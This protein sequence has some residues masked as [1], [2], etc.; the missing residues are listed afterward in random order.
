MNLELQRERRLK[1]RTFGGISMEMAIRAEIT[2]E[3]WRRVQGP[4]WMRC[5][6]KIKSVE[7]G[8]QLTKD[9][10]KEQLMQKEEIQE[11]SVTWKPKEESV[12]RR[13]EG[14]LAWLWLRC[15]K[16]SVSGFGHR[17]FTEDL[18]GIICRWLELVKEGTGGR[19]CLANWLDSTSFIVE[20][21]RG[22]PLRALGVKGSCFDDCYCLFFEFLVLSTFR[23]ARRS[24]E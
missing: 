21:R 11:I 2:K 4:A 5:H 23:L 17:Q 22:L 15:W 3:N 6:F 18:G 24:Q 20:G 14:S 7:R 16:W 12:S 10:E 19:K 9:V 13:K 1:K 8:E